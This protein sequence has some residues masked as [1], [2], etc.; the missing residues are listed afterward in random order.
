MSQIVLNQLLNSAA[1]LEMTD[2][3]Q[4]AAQVNFLLAQRKVPS[5]S[6]SEAELLQT[7]NQGLPESTQRRYD[8]L[9]GK[10]R[11]ETITPAEHQEFLALVDLVEQA[12]ADRLQHLI[13]LSQLRQVSLPTLMYQ[14]GIQ[15]PAIHV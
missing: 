13:T 11:A 10:L 14:L 15:P 12:D 4:L 2:L 8:E 5:L 9:R 7:I 6:A 3:E 1:Q